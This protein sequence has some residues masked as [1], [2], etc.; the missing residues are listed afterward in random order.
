MNKIHASSA[1]H[2]EAAEDFTDKL[3]IKKLMT[4]NEMTSNRFVSRAMRWTIF[5]LSLVWLTNQLG[6]FIVDKSYMSIVCASCAVVLLIPTVIVDMLKIYHPSVKYVILSLSIIFVAILYSVLT[7]HCVVILMLPLFLAQLYFDRNVTIYTIVSSL[8][9]LAI[10][11]AVSPV[12]HILAEENFDSFYTAMVYGY[13]PRAMEFLCLSVVSVLVTSRA[14]G[15]LHKVFDSNAQIDRNRDA[16]KKVVELSSQLFGTHS[17]YEI[18]GRITT[19]LYLTVKELKPD[20]RNAKAAVAVRTSDST[21]MYVRED[22]SMSIIGTNTTGVI[23]AVREKIS[24]DLELDAECPE[25]SLKTTEDG[26]FMSFYEDGKLLA[27]VI[28]EASIPQHDEIFHR[29]MKILH[30]NIHLALKNAVLAEDMQ[31]TQEELIFSF[32]E[33][34]ESKS[35]QTG[36]H[37]KRVSE[38]MKIMATELGLPSQEVRNLGLAAMMHDVGKL[39]IPS[40]I[41]E[42]PGRLTAEEFDIIKT[43]VTIGRDLLKHSPGDVM[44]MATKIAYEHHEKWDGTGYLGMAGEQIDFYSRMMAVVDVFDALVSNRSYK[45]GWPPGEAHDEIVNQSGKHFDPQVVELFKRVYP[46]FLDILASYPDTEAA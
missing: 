9:G 28:L 21:F 4:E 25:Y 1:K 37:I 33:I 45:R 5:A 35:E 2:I 40:E 31:K 16:L 34:S 13:L 41:I 11:H 43:H 36:Q 44:A 20:I 30:T 10:A 17:I 8:A 12:T 15:M 39:L 19:S 32:A 27:F 18:A 29:V 3:N 7:F 42:K 6:L 23:T 22:N 24:Y 38:Y 14:G 26:I 46:K